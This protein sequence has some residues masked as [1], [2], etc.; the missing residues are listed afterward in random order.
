MDKIWIK[1]FFEKKINEIW[2]KLGETVFQLYPD[3]IQISSGQ[4]LDKIMIKLD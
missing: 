2:I 4:D 3:L 1:L